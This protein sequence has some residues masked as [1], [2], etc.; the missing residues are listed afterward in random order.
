MNKWM[1]DFK[2]EVKTSTDRME[3]RADVR[4]A[5][6]NSRNDVKDK[7]RSFVIPRWS[8]ALGAVAA[9]VVI[10]AIV[11]AVILPGSGIIPPSGPS[12]SLSPSTGTSLRACVVETNP[13]VMFLADDD[14]T[15]TEVKR[16]NSDA[17]MLFSDDNS[18]SLVGK[19]LEEALSDYAELLAKTGFIDVD[20]KDNAI[21]IS[22]YGIES[23][24]ISSL[25]NSMLDTLSTHGIFSVV[26]AGEVDLSTLTEL[27][28]L[29]SDTDNVE[30]VVKDLIP[31]Y[32]ERIV[33]SS[34]ENFEELLSRY[35]T[36]AYEEVMTE[37]RLNADRLISQGVILSE[38]AGYNATILISTDNPVLFGRYWD[39][40][41]KELPEGGPCAVA[42]KLMEDKL[43]E[44]EEKF[45]YAIESQAQLNELTEAYNEMK[46]EAL[47]EALT[48][49][50]I[51][52]VRANKELLT[53]L[54]KLA[55]CDTTAFDA[56][57]DLPSDV[58]EY[59]E[60]TLDSYKKEF[61]ARTE[62]YSEAFSAE[63]KE[64]S[65][66]DYEEYISDIVE[67]YGSLEAYWTAIKK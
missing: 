62:M 21:R 41:D 53:R 30:K 50:S 4:R 43:K 49:L 17:E 5:P 16:L 23:G 52:F 44:F 8:M 63:R 2:K 7:K 46:L 47:T 24:S 28:G 25:K 32:D 29:S 6:I 38:L 20:S 56:L 61:A 37:I 13:S 45:G 48:N 27:I 1:D 58:D 11:L 35:E 9:C 40:K 65:S 19:S 31:S 39:V 60:K 51:E 42:V 34:S 64:I 12:G 3:M 54:M 26:L 59:L 14:L 33:D 18:V 66:S 55:G 67:E 15:V 36:L 57:L 22:G 10:V